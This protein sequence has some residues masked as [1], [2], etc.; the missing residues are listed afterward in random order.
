MLVSNHY[1]RLSWW[2]GL[3]GALLISAIA[4]RR[5]DVEMHN[6]ATDRAHIGRFI[7]PGTQWLIERVAAAW[8]LVLVTPPSVLLNSTLLVFCRFVLSWE[9]LYHCLQCVY[10][11][12]Y[13]IEDLFS[14]G[15][16]SYHLTLVVSKEH[17]QPAAPQAVPDRETCLTHHS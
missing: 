7:I 16:S 10:C 1:Q 17:H 12:A 15:H 5:A 8:D 2:I 3:S 13:L 14:P 9:R 4:Q 6:V 11:L